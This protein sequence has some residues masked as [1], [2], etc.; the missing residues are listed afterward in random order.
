MSSKPMRPSD[1]LERRFTSPRR[2]D[3]LSALRIEMPMRSGLAGFTKKSMAPPRMAWTTVSMPPVAVSTITGRSG[4]RSISRSSVS[5]PDRPGMTRSSRTT[6][7]P[8]R[9]SPAS[10]SARSPF[11]TTRA[12][13]PCFSAA[14]CIRRRW[15][16]SSSTTRTVLAMS[17]PSSVDGRLL[18]R[19]P[20]SA[21]K[22]HARLKMRL[23]GST[24]FHV[25]RG[26]QGFLRQTGARIAPLAMGRAPD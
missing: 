5:M 10:S 12:R 1:F 15:V 7:T 13:K 25:T 21:S 8:L 20:C 23:S 6:S 24:Q 4:R 19:P 26:K 9:G 16:G 2:S 3:I 14:A 22:W 11:S 17:T 18:E